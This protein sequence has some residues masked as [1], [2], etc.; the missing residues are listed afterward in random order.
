MNAIDIKVS[1]AKDLDKSVTFFDERASM[2]VPN[3]P[4][5]TGKPAIAKAIAGSFAAGDVVYTSDTYRFSFKDSSGKS[6][7]KSTLTRFGATCRALLS[8]S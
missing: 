8:S 4:I 1:S 5:A 6:A 2:L 3:M 7:G